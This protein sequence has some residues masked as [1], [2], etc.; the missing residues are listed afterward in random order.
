MSFLTDQ[1]CFKQRFNMR[2]LNLSLV[3][4]CCSLTALGFSN[5][6]LADG[7]AISKVLHQTPTNA[8]FSMCYGGGCA[9]VVALSLSDAEWQVITQTFMPKPANAE[10]ERAAI[11]QAIGVFEQ[12]VGKKTNTSD[13]KAGTFGNSKFPNQLDCNDE[14][15]NTTNYMRL[16]QAAGYLQFHQ[17]IDTKTRGYFIKGWPH[18][19]AAIQ[20]VSNNEKFAVDSWF[21]DNGQPATIVPLALWKSGWKPEKAT[22]H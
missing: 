8:A 21:Y 18:S 12:I 6:T 15:A 1:Y 20:E 22:A 3:V 9:E 19:T 13:D 16:L 10:Q 17:I 2:F 11:S 4:L 5:T 14:A 7:T